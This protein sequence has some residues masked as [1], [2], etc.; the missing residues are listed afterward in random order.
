M[1]KLPNLWV[2]VKTENAKMPSGDALM[3]SFVETATSHIAFPTES[4]DRLIAAAKSKVTALSAKMTKLIETSASLPTAGLTCMLSGW[5]LSTGTLAT[6]LTIA[7]QESGF[8]IDARSASHAF[9]LYQTLPSRLKALPKIVAQLRPEQRELINRAAFTFTDRS[10]DELLEIASDY[11][12]YVRLASKTPFLQIVPNALTL[13]GSIKELDLV[14]SFVNGTLQWNKRVDN[15]SALRLLRGYDGREQFYSARL[16]CLSSL[17]CQGLPW[18]IHGFKPYASG[19]AARLLRGHAV[20]SRYK[21]SLTVLD[22]LQT[23][24]DWQRLLA[25]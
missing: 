17:H 25:K 19:H 12:K 7:E 23:V 1:T 21:D 22:W 8:Q 6:F 5:D 3:N 24:V 20:F 14:T 9:G 13:V 18:H 4:A 16:F 2:P 15:P 11:P 10:L